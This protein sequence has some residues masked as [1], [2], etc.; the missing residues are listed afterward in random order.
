MLTQPKTSGCRSIP[1]ADV[2]I[3]RNPSLGENQ[4]MTELI[5]GG[6]LCGAVRYES[7]AEPHFAGHCQCRDCE[8][9]TGTG[10][11]SHLGV[12]TGE[13][14]ISGEL[15]HYDTTAESGN[16]S[17]RSFCAI[18]GSPVLF[19]TS[20]FEGVIGITAGSLDDPSLFKPGMVVFTDSAPSWDHIDPA[21][22]R[23]PRDYIDPA[24]QRFPRMPKI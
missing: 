17:T 15:R 16:I 19:K 11:S 2:T 10:H 24:L 21:L 1:D 5:T 6:C 18:C 7:R 20:G 23:F 8:K 12:P 13:L 9:S 3:V 22:R 14:R 4:Q